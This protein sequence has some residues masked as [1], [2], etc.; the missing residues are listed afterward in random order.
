M[1]EFEY[2]SRYL[3]TYKVN[4]DEII[5][6]VCPFCGGGE[7]RDKNTFALNH[8]NHTYNCKRGSCGVSGHF[9]ELLKEKGETF[10]D[11]YYSGKPYIKPKKEYKKPETKYGGLTD[12]AAA[13]IAARKISPET[14]A[15]FGVSCDGKGNLVFPY[16]RTRE[17]REHQNPTFIKF[18]IP[19]KVTQ[20]RKMWREAD[21]MPILYNLD[22]CD[23]AKGILYITEGEFDAMALYQATGG[24]VNVTSV[25][26]GAEDFTWIETCAD[27]LSKYKAFAVIGDNDLPG[28]K[29]ANEIVTK[30]DSGGIKVFVPDYTT[31]C[32]C[33]DCNEILVRYGENPFVSIIGSL[34]DVPPKGL[35]NVADIEWMDFGN[36]PKTRTGIKSIDSETGGFLEGDITVWT[37]KRGSGK[38]TFLTQLILQSIEDG[39]KVCCYSGEIPASRFKRNILLCASGSSYLVEKTDNMTGRIYYAPRVD[40]AEYINRWIDRKLWLY[41]N[42]IIEKDESK[43]IID[44]FIDAYKRYDC[45]VFVVDNLMTVNCNVRAAEVMQTQAN[46]VIQLH[47][48]A[49]IYHTHVHI[50]AHPRKGDEVKDADD[51]GGLG[52]ITNIAHN[53][54]CV[55]EKDTKP[56]EPDGSILRC[57]KNREFKDYRDYSLTFDKK[58]RRFGELYQPPTKYG[59]EMAWETDHP[60][61][62]NNTKGQQVS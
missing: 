22:R 19:E 35:I 14:A 27:E 12:K 32:G 48:F 33:K 42:K 11:S 23:P 45:R 49:E 43:S 28:L 53:A 34:H 1:N 59:W 50:V 40:V 30:L 36:T 26:S 54:Y 51:V 60:N 7:H 6:T 62:R 15:A 57:L 5:P 44:R 52:V 47:Q 21:T 16:Y 13:Y 39:Q 58:S 55:M 37:G 29:M 9:S 8:R 56:G 4:G 61:E 38:S 18:R 2:A 20:G 24:S 46:I 41:D 3:G 25:P 10:E 17:D 31:Y